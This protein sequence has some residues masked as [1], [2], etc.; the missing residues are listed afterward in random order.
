M[1]WIKIT[2]M[3][4][5]HVTDLDR[6]LLRARSHVERFLHQMCWYR[7]TTRLLRQVCQLKSRMHS[8][9]RWIPPR[10]M[11]SS[12]SGRLRAGQRLFDDPPH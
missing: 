12:T 9:E 7:G 10:I 3:L 8:M 4:G 6:P 11:L 2:V 5:M 1:S